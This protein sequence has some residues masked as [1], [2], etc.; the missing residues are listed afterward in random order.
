MNINLTLFAVAAAFALFIW[1]T[2][3]FVWPPLMIAIEK[4]QKQIAEGLEAAEEGKRSLVEAERRNE[5]SIKEAR[6]RVQ[7]LL[8]D[9]ERRASQIVDD[10]K[11]HAKGEADRILAAAQ[12][13]IQQEFTKA[14]GELREQVAA[15]AISGAEQ[16]LKREVDARAH[17][18]ML[19]KLKAQL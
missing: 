18:E 8:I 6:D 17:A 7:T 9:G 1:F 4:R 5:V 10:A 13:Q 11:V 2:S 19:G 16:I 12:E 15:L 3:K 14:K